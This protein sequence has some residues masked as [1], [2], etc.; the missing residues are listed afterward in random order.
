MKKIDRSKIETWLVTGCSSGFGKE[1]CIELLK[2]N[3]KVIATA[4]NVEKLDYLKEFAKPE[5]FLALP[6]NVTDKEQVKKVIHESLAVFGKID[7]LVNN[8]GSL[9][10]SD[11]ENE[12]EEE[13]RRLFEINFWAVNN[14]MKVI[15]PSMR[16]NG[17]GTIV[18]MSSTVGI[19]GNMGCPMYAASKHALEGL[20]E[21]FSNNVDFALRTMLVEPCNFKTDVRYK[22]IGNSG[23]S[24]QDTLKSYNNQESYNDTSVGAKII[25]NAV[26]A[27]RMPKRLLLGEKTYHS[28]GEA[29]KLLKKARKDYKKFGLPCTIINNKKIKLF[30]RLTLT[31]IR[32]EENIVKYYLFGF[33]P[34]LT[35]KVNI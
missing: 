16:N 5:N 29:I 9:Y 27:K 35:K 17:Y 6:L 3:Y 21:A 24:H 8:A 12:K 30:N 1:I 33:L 23:L 14:M 18:N 25:I 19:I 32:R 13:S 22:A 11:F 26:E 28:A 15:L 31:K 7:V 4:R 20:H 2:R 10:M 34:I